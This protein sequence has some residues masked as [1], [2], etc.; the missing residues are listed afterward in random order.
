MKYVYGMLAASLFLLIS[1]GYSYYT[2]LWVPPDEERHLAYCEYIAQNRSLPYL[3]ANS[4]GFRIGQA[5]HPPLF[6]LI[7]SLFC[8]K[9]S[10]KLILSTVSVNEGPGFAVIVPPADGITP[11]YAQKA[12]SAH[13][14]R[15]FSLI[16]SALTVYL[17]YCMALAVFPRR[18]LLAFTAALL[19][20]NCPEFVHV[21]ASVSNEP[22][23]T[24]LATLYVLIL[25]HWAKNPERIT[26]SMAAGIVLG[27][28]LL[29]KLSAV[30][31]IPVTIIAIVWKLGGIGRK[32]AKSL[33]VIFVPAALIS[34][35]WLLRNWIYFDDPVFLKAIETMQP[36]ALRQE[37]FSW[38]YLIMVA[39]MTF[40]S[41]FGLLGSLNMPLESIHLS[42][43][44][45][46]ITLGCI[47]LM[48]LFIG[49]TTSVAQRQLLWLLAVSLG[50]GVAFYLQ[51]NFRYTMF[52]GRY[53]FI[54]IAPWSILISAGLRML[55]PVRWRS[56][57]LLLA[58]CLLVV[59]NMDV[60]LR[61]VKPA[62][63]ETSL[64]TGTS[65]PEFC[66]SSF[67]VNTASEV[68]QTFISS[69]NNLCAV[70]VM[71]SC[72]GDL[73]H[74]GEVLFTLKEADR[75][76]TAI[77][78]IPLPFGDLHDMSKYYFVFPPIADSHNKR[79]ILSFAVSSAGSNGRLGLWY[80]RPQIYRDG[81]M[82]LN[83]NPL[84]GSLYFATYHFSGIEPA[85]IWEGVRETCI[86]QGWY[87][88][89][90]ELQYYGELARDLREKTKTHEKLKRIEK[91]LLNRSQL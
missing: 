57:G 37:A 30:L 9:D 65:Q 70:Q 25:M 78:T 41:F 68:S 86:N 16:C 80:E 5:L 88:G 49:G 71:F 8:R 42:F 11:E 24:A 87:V 75:N 48:P 60:L 21:S 79:Y 81:A 38:S 53:L 1:S 34:A 59:V 72:G 33:L 12:W 55:I 85:M 67:F 44:A 51:I 90:R 52:M 84:D 19:V 77:C 62:Y 36:W 28:C 43:Y 54:V 74:Q 6:Y 40:Q 14:I 91:A 4:D 29:T 23:S 82:L 73:S 50:A 69:Q 3:D 26:Y 56:C 7:G 58:G 15:L 39:S 31:Y 27:L 17:T 89:C 76:Q 22:L 18:V 20:G 13:I 32:S 61:V 35:W 83:G 2:P 46:M 45:L 10:T 64:Q 63:A 47:G 66:C